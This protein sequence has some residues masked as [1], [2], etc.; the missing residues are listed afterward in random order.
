MPWASLLIFYSGHPKHHLQ[1]QAKMALKHR[2]FLNAATQL[3]VSNPV[4]K[5]HRLKTT[6]ISLINMI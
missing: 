4:K 3:P 1:N 5:A 2:C 6:A